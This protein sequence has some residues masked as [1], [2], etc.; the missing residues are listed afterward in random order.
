MIQP[1]NITKEKIENKTKQILSKEYAISVIN[2]VKDSY[3]TPYL[4]LAVVINIIFFPLA[5]FIIPYMIHK[6]VN[7]QVKNQS[8]FEKLQ[9]IALPVWGIAV[10]EIGGKKA[11]ILLSGLYTII[12][13]TLFGLIL[14]TS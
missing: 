10:V 6:S 14:Y 4:L 9:T 12:L 8:T 13:L 11:Q 3:S 2:A 5:L 1:S 7:N